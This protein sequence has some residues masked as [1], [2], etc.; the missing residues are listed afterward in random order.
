MHES[1]RVCGVKTMEPACTNIVCLS[2][3]TSGIRSRFGAVLYSTLKMVSSKECLAHEEII[4]YESYEYRIPD[5]EEEMFRV[6]MKQQNPNHD[7]HSNSKNSNAYCGD[8]NPWS[9]RLKLS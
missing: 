1:L 3:R 7:R 2:S 9:Y 6:Y 8:L 4:W 5:N